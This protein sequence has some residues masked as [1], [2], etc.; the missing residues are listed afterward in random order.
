MGSN[1]QIAE[2]LLHWYRVN[3]RNLPWRETKDPYKIWVSEII[4][5]QTRVNQGLDY[6]IRFI[7]KFPNIQSLAQ[8][9][10]DE[11]MK[12][13]QGL[14][15][16]SRARNMHFAAK[17]VLL[18]FNGQFPSTYNHILKLKGIGKYT[19]AAIA[20]IAFNEV[21][22]VVDGNVYR[23]LSRLNQISTPIDDAKSYNEFF[24]VSSKMI[25]PQSPGDYNQAVM[26]LGA[27]ICHPTSPECPECP[28]K[29][30][31]KAFKKGNT[32]DFPVKNKK[33]AIR[34]RYFNYLVIRSTNNTLLLYKRNGND[35]WNSL[36]EFPMFESLNAEIHT[37][38][39]ITRFKEII[40][41]LKLKTTEL[42]KPV[43]QVQK[44][45]HQIIH[46]RFYEIK[47]N[48]PIAIPDKF[49]WTNADNLND[50]AVHKLIDN[51]LKLVVN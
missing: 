11:L 19:A 46:A 27:L 10:E 39:L 45:S 36:Y 24:T 44:L 29:N 14:G 8:A 49:I 2:L 9:H 43:T 35:V 25:D 13:W 22:P 40:P 26:E 30:Y 32:G 47:Y 34:T 33:T 48:A 12:L 41:S 31:C 20:S 23:V 6:Y 7:K 18:E 16:Y 4:L 1:N 28:V 15:Y 50:F 51:Y 17:Q 37:N 5:Q 38:E 21:V 42:K 3:K